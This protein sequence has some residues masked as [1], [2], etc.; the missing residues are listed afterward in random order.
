MAKL[1]NEK[2]KAVQS[3]EWREH[4]KK[5]AH[6]STTNKKTS[7]D[8]MISKPKGRPGRSG[9]DGY[10]IREAMRVSGPQYNYFV[11]CIRTLVIKYLDITVPLSRQ[12]NRLLV[13]KV[14]IKAQSVCP[15]LQQYEGA[16][17]VRNIM[18]QYLRNRTTQD[19]QRAKA[20]KVHLK[21][22]KK[23]KKKWA[24]SDS[25]SEDLDA[26]EERKK[27]K[28]RIC[29]D[30]ESDSDLDAKIHSK[31]K[32]KRKLACLDSES[33]SESDLESNLD[34]DAKVHSKKKTKSK[35]ARSDLESDSESDSNLDAKVHSKKKKRKL[36]HSDSESEDLDV[37]V[38]SKKT[39]KK[40]KQAHSDS[41]SDPENEDLE[42]SDDS[43][44]GSELKSD[45]K[46]KHRSRHPS[47]RLTQ[48]IIVS[49]SEDNKSDNDNKMAD[50]SSSDEEDISTS[51]L[52]PAPQLTNAARTEKQAR[53]GQ[54]TTAGPRKA[55]PESSKNLI[56]AARTAKQARKDQDVTGVDQAS[57]GNQVWF[58]NTFI[59]LLLLVT[60]PRSQLMPQEP[61]SRR[62]KNKTQPW[63]QKKLAPNHLRSQLMLQGLRSEPKRTK[64]L[65][66]WFGQAPAI[67]NPIPQSTDAARTE[68]QA[69]KDHDTTAAPEKAGPKP[70]QKHH[71]DS[72][73]RPE[74]DLDT[75]TANEIRN[76]DFHSDI[77]D[78]EVMNANGDQLRQCPECK[79]ELPSLISP[80][81]AAHFKDYCKIR[82]KEGCILRM[83]GELNQLVFDRK[84]L[85]D[86]FIWKAFKTSLTDD[87]LSIKQFSTLKPVSPLLQ[88]ILRSKPGYYGMKGN[89]IITNMLLGLFP[90][91]TT[92]IDAFY[93]LSH[94][95][96]FMFVLVPYIGTELITE[97]LRVVAPG[98]SSIPNV[99]TT[100]RLM[101]SAGRIP[102]PS[103]CLDRKLKTEVDES[104][105]AAAAALLE[106]NMNAT[107]MEMTTGNE[108][109]PANR[110]HKD[111]KTKRTAKANVE[112]KEHHTRARAKAQPSK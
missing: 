77:S 35:Q 65:P 31:K 52:N 46:L 54:D 66:G 103:S 4:H 37:K 59:M 22:N 7:K 24:H 11:H 8:Q 48:R 1:K 102:P 44:G 78:S 20:V 34:L 53:K 101:H 79:E 106:L 6:H 67:S 96:F 87:Q 40:S 47:K 69:R 73:K 27:K 3:R 42:S 91:Q 13:E 32:K 81:L 85:E 21:K 104:M 36:V 62:E 43:D 107:S 74:A 109:V 82:R 89:T 83:I 30:S 16:W 51:S 108:G 97:D 86:S 84:Y 58:I 28:K 38:H 110:N 88:T 55:G 90:Q 76:I 33:D 111:K 93:P 99:M 29:S 63:P 64:M 61:K 112:T 57:A 56:D 14:I 39:K 15:E 92:P 71:R 95:Q 75:D 23:K 18:G 98:K 70:S 5:K 19:R 80:Q 2:Q 68:N 17:A 9:A 60:P 49:E 25:E 12:P 41:E 50:P 100:T 10:N 26:K 45:L 94:T 105:K 72:A